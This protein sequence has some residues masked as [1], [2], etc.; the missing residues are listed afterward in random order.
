MSKSTEHII[1][2]IGFS[3]LFSVAYFAYGFWRNVVEGDYLSCLGSVSNEIQTLEAT[4]DLTSKNNNWKILN[5]DEVNFLMQKVRGGDCGGFDNP[6]LDIWNHRI[7]I[8]LRKST[9]YP[10]MIIWSNGRD[11]VSGTEDDLIMPY[12]KKVPNS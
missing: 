12:G 8:A 1:I 7:N 11:N 5:D 2:I 6:I 4:K 10:D 9:E 3:L